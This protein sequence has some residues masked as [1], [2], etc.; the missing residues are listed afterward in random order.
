MDRDILPILER[1][2]Q[3]VDPEWFC[4][5][6]LQRRNGLVK[7]EFTHSAISQYEQRIEELKTAVRQARDEKNRATNAL[8]LMVE[9]SAN[10]V[11]DTQLAR[12]HFIN[13]MSGGKFQVNLVLGSG[14]QTIIDEQHTNVFNITEVRQELQ[15]ETVWQD[16]EDRLEG[17]TAD[18]AVMMD[19]LHDL[20]GKVLSDVNPES[21]LSAEDVAEKVVE[22]LGEKYNLKK[23]GTDLK[24]LGGELLKDSAGSILGQFFM[25]VGVTLPEIL[26]LNGLL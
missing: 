5:S 25:T 6:I 17:L 13:T 3:D 14:T 20:H 16:I 2:L 1:K 24:E 7:A 4:E 22:I 18:S 11:E 15:N 21:S 8:I 19:F 26:R 12:R 10:V 9:Q 23:H